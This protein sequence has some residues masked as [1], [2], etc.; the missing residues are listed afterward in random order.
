MKKYSRYLLIPLFA[1]VGALIFVNLFAHV[2]FRMEALKVGL[3]V[4]SSLVGKTRLEIPPVGEVTANTHKTPISLSISLESIDLDRLKKLLAQGP[5]QDKLLS[6]AKNVL[7]SEIRRF[8]YLTLAI[9]FAGGVFGVLVL[10]GKRLKELLA[11]GAIG[12]IVVALLLGGTYKTFDVQKFSNPEYEGALKAAPW[13][14]GLVQEGLS[15]VNTWG[16]EM[17]FI[18]NNLYGL[19]QRVESLQAVSPGEGEIK[20]LHVSDIHN[21]PVSFDF[22]DQVAKT[23][24]VDFVI[25]SGDMSDFGTP[26]E[27]AM[28]ERVKNL[29]VPYVFVPGNH[30]TSGIIDDL[31]KTPNIIVIDSGV[32]GI[33][34]LKIAAIGDP[35][36]HT[37]DYH[38]PDQSQIDVYSAKLQQIIELSKVNPDIVVAHNPNI[39]QN[40]WGKYPVVLCGHD[41][42]YK[43][44]VK[45]NFV[46]I[47]AGTSGAAG[48]G[49]FRTKAEIPYTFVLLHFDRSKNGLKL[50]YTDTISIS[51]K[52]S[53]YSLERKVYSDLTDD[54]KI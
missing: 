33:K 34:G 30:E 20:V 31:K 7:F 8:V 17:R 29:K 23:F 15:T 54:T 50:K 40:F 12:L 2:D 21:N 45:P 26:L 43:I 22:I 10:Q 46:M 51:N 35:S 5:V 37:S 4:H 39:A 14:I 36:S 32:K 16:K 18:A 13:M 24:G 48:I 25:D 38:A 1:I 44:K 52:Q 9:G 19:F 53:G 11:G 47:D 28:L 41:H 3:S 49:A 27:S 42:Q 6:E